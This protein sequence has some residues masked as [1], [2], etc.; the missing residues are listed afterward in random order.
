MIDGLFRGCQ[1]LELHLFVIPSQAGTIVPNH[2]F[3][4]MIE[5]CGVE[6]FRKGDFVPADSGIVRSKSN[7][8]VPFQKAMVPYLYG[9]TLQVHALSHVFACGECDEIINLHSRTEWSSIR[10]NGLFAFFFCTTVWGL[11]NGRRRSER[12]YRMT[13]KR[14]SSY[15]S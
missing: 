15:E 3:G 9:V 8:A 5:H 14:C 13:A 10:A 6:W 12:C 7:T 2:K 1:E 11:L 4:M